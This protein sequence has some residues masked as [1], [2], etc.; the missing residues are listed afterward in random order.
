MSRREAATGLERESRWMRLG[1]AA[2]VGYFLALAWTLPDFGVTW[3]EPSA[4]GTGDRHMLSFRSLDLTRIEPR[5][6]MGGFDAYGPL[7]S[8]ASSFAAALLHHQLGWLEE[9]AARHS[10]NVV[11]AML[12]AVSIWLLLLVREDGRV[13]LLGLLG[14]VALPRWFGH[15]HSNISDMPAA[16]CVLAALCCAAVWA[17][18]GGY[19]WLVGLG[20]SLGAATAIRPQTAIL[21]PLVIGGWIA[22]DG[23]L[24]GRLRQRPSLLLFVAGVTLLSV[25]VLWPM[26]WIAPLSSASYVVD[27]F[28]NPPQLQGMSPV[29]YLGERYQGVRLWHYPL[30][31]TAVTTPLPVLGLSIWGAVAGLRRSAPSRRT[32]ARLAVWWLIVTLGSHMLMVRGNY[33]GVRHFLE[34]FGAIAWLSGIGANDILIRMTGRLPRAGR[35]LTHPLAVMMVCGLLLVP[36]TTAIARH[37]PYPQIYYNQLV[38]GTA[39]AADLFDLDYWGFSW[40]SGME[41][42]NREAGRGALLLVPW[43]QTLHGYYKREDLKAAFALTREHLQWRLRQE[44]GAKHP[45]EIYFLFN[46]RRSMISEADLVPY[47]RSTFPRVHG[48][49]SNGVLLFEVYRVDPGA[50][51]GGER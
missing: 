15:A 13:A 6:G 27:F 21:A 48:V 29:F 36:G 2:L 3:D 7:S 19:R 23:Q 20:V 25:W 18:R 38:G 22:V 32:S 10:S 35:P 47:V 30:L 40:K 5:P 26:F 50:A 45:R 9:D 12:A 11:F 39:G 44:S 46:V 51:L 33:D 37:H 49:I 14:F 43:D 34:A 4:F 24:R 31:M 17:K 1:L 8:I 16:A 41:W 28:M 42:V